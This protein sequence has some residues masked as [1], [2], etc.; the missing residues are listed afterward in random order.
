MRPTGATS[1]GS[2]PPLARMHR[3]IN[4]L[5]GLVEDCAARHCKAARRNLSG[6]ARGKFFRHWATALRIVLPTSRWR[7]ASSVPGATPD[8]C[9]SLSRISSQ[10]AWKF[11]ARKEAHAD[12]VR[13]GERIARGAHGLFRARQ[14]RWL[15]SPLRVEVGS[16][17]S[18]GSTPRRSFA[19]TGH[20]T[21]DGP[22]HR[23]PPWRGDLGGSRRWRLAAGF[24]LYAA[25]VIAHAARGIRRRRP[26]TR[27]T[28]RGPS[29]RAFGPE[30]A[31]QGACL[32]PSQ[33]PPRGAAR[34]VEFRASRSPYRAI[35][36][37]PLYR[38]ERLAFGVP[39]S[40]PLCLQSTQ[41]AFASR[42]TSS[43]KH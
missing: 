27:Y 4:D 11:T 33:P 8:C 3:L 42:G 19:G 34:Q 10:N 26:A 1:S 6:L 9:E 23:P 25:A 5:L 30:P 40:P 13:Q 24:L 38:R 21:G 22:A 7:K 37:P 15:R 14:R 39:P 17:R 16:A 29:P 32:A 31:D 43:G 12:R 35:P 18:R 2:R 28:L 41:R 36:A 20:R